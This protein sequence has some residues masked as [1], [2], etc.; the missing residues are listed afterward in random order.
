[1]K[2]YI[3]GIIMAV[4]AFIAMLPLQA[5][6][7][8]KG[9]V[10]LEVK[11]NN[12]AEV[13]VIVPEAAGERVSSLQL[14]LQITDQDG[15]SVG[16]EVLDQIDTP[17][18]VWSQEVLER[19]KITEQR[20][21][22]ETGVL[23]L[24]ISGTEPLFSAEGEEPDML[25][26]GTVTASVKD[27]EAVGMTLYMSMAPDSFKIVRGAEAVP[28][29]VPTMDAVPLIAGKTPEQPPNPGDGGQEPGDDRNPGDDGQEPGDNQNPGDDGQNPGNGNPPNPGSSGNG[30]GDSGGVSTQPGA[31][32]SQ[33][34]EI[35]KIAEGYRE[36]DYT[37]ESYSLL[38]QVIREGQ[39]VLDDPNASQEDVD[40]AVQA[41]QNAIG[42]LVPAAAAGVNTQNDRN[43]LYGS[44]NQAVGTG[45]AIS[46]KLSI[47]VMV[48]GAA[49]FAGVGM[50]K[51]NRKRI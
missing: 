7:A 21:Q 12:M 35:L 27:E 44:Q 40:R 19:A 13:S 39:A 28:I 26:L 16:Q 29:P 34:Q 22:S 6:A 3:A 30:T 4:F 48:F 41:I 47:C 15:N 32:K 5:S 1:M 33:L 23:R 10:C 50:W 46:W 37:W 38:R 17:S 20:Y 25:A 9:R 42:G 24:Y 43:T 11:E 18:F 36:T 31:D 49:I 8:Q 14:G 2:K 45:D 51:R